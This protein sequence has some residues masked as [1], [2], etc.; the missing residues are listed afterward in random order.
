MGPYVED[1]VGPSQHVLEEAKKEWKG[2]D[3]QGLDQGERNRKLDKE[4]LINLGALYW[5]IG[6]NKLGNGFFFCI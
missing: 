2:L 3:L 4:E 1:A 5:D 6:S